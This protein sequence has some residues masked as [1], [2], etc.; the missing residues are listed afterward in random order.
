MIDKFIG[1]NKKTKLSVILFSIGFILL[2][3]VLVGQSY[4]IFSGTNTDS[5]NQIVK[6]WNLEVIL[7]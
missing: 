4:A 1:L 5:N 3:I 2:C 6:L 7:N